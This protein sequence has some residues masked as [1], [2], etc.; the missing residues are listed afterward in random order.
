[1]NSVKYPSPLIASMVPARLAA[2]KPPF[3]RPVLPAAEKIPPW[4]FSAP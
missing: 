3:A 2:G 4:N 1:M